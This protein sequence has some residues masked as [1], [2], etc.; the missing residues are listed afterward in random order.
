MMPTGTALLLIV[1]ALIYF[2]VGQRL[3][4]RMQLTDTQALIAIALM[5][6]GSFITIPLYQ[7]RTSV[8]LNVGGAV[9]PLALVIYL[10]VRADTARERIR[11]L[12]AALVTGGIVYGV[13]QFTDFDPSSPSLFID[14]LWLF[15]IVAGVVGYLSGR[16]RRASFIAGV[17][18]ILTVDIVHLGLALANNMATRVVLGGAGVFDATIVAGLIAVALAEFVGETRERIAGGGG[19]A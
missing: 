19:E 8:N 18:G 3:L 15:S 1:A 7:G 6:G 2:G 11:S 16:S 10:L 13:S 14:P 5:I 9:V 4:D 17:L 12:V